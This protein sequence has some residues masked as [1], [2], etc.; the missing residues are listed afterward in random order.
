MHQE[1]L[2]RSIHQRAIALALPACTLASMWA[3]TTHATMALAASPAPVSAGPAIAFEPNAGQAPAGVR[4]LAHTG[5]G[6]VALT[7]LGAELVLSLGDRPSPMA[8]HRPTI[9]APPVLLVVAERYVGA[10]S[11]LLLTPSSPLH[12]RVSYML[13]S[14]PA[15]WHADLPTYAV[16]TAA[17][18]YPGVDLAWSSSGGRLETTYTVA[19]GADPSRIRWVEAGATAIT[20]DSG[21]SLAIT[22]PR[23]DVGAVSVAPTIT[24]QPPLAW[25]ETP[26]GRS[27]VSAAYRVDATGAVGFTLGAHDPALPLVIDPVVQYATYL[28]ADDVPY[29]LGVDVAGDVVVSGH[30]G[31]TSF[32][33]TPGAYQGSNAG[34]WDVFVSKLDPGTGALIW[35][36]Y[37]G[38]SSN[39]GAFA[40]A[41]DPRGAVAVTGFAGASD[42]PTTAGAYQTTVTKVGTGVDAFVLRLSPDGATL[43]AS[44]LLGGT[45][46][47]PNNDNI[48]FGVPDDEDLGTDVAI[49]ADGAMTVGG[50]TSSVDF[51]TTAGAYQPVNRG[52]AAD[53]FVARV[54]ADARTLV[55][56]TFLGGLDYDFA[57]GVVLESGGD[58]AVTGETTSTDFPTS[59]GAYQARNGDGFSVFLARLSGDLTTLRWSTYYGGTRGSNGFQYTVP[60]NLAIDPSGNLLVAGETNASDLPVTAGAYQPSLGGQNDAYVAAISPDGASLRYASYLG[61]SDYDGAFALALDDG[62]DIWVAGYTASRDLPVTPDAPQPTYTDGYQGGFLSELAP[63]A[64]A[65]LFSTHIGGATS[66]NPQYEPAWDEAYDVAAGAGGEIAIAGITSC[67]DFPVTANATQPTYGGGYLAAWVMVLRPAAPSPGVPEAPL[68]VLLMAPAGLA[69][70]GR[71]IRRRP[72]R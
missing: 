4:F 12:G 24:E 16:V 17:H 58:V 66:H 60:S 59:S 71:R 46:E 22:L 18:L 25:Q 52:G 44:T 32:P 33:V 9:P 70:L 2:R 54:S 5:G 28:G 63:G 47:A 43:E 48:R 27:R 29:G 26:G 31:S 13:G 51:P 20:V 19:A 40:L 64:A 53:A 7:G 49:G 45:V 15:A 56:S 55:G 36:T 65:L 72:P 14:D 21:G 11:P 42:F 62:G 10:S 1:R 38:S 68:A 50:E 39:D 34:H 8:A 35:S 61:G 41:L 67:T 69:F 6:I 3:P 30:T 57:S 23:V 37:I